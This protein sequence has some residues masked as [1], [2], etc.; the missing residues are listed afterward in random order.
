MVWASDRPRPVRMRSRTSCLSRCTLVGAIRRR[1]SRCAVTL[2]PRNLRS[3]GLATALFSALMRS[4]KA[5][6]RKVLT[7]LITRLPA[8]R[9][10][11]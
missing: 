4:F 2:N 8:T 9:L 7:A 6:S 1:V 10:L 5:A 3:Q 11:T